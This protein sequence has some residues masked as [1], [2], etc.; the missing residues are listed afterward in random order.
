MRCLFQD[1]DVTPAE[2]AV[3][4][5][6]LTANNCT[7]VTEITIE[8]L[9]VLVHGNRHNGRPVTGTALRRGDLPG[10]LMAALIRMRS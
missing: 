9:A 4:D 5:A 7:G 10:E 8:D 1:A 2:R 3:V 6:W